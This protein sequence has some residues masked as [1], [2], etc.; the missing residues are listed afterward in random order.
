M[1]KNIMSGQIQNYSLTACTLSPLV[2]VFGENI[3][4]NKLRH[5]VVVEGKENLRM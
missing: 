1:H 5:L 4:G 2:K 3:H